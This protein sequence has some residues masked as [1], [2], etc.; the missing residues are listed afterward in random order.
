[1][2]SSVRTGGTVFVLAGGGSLGAV[3]VG[4]LDALVVAGVTPDFVLG[5]SVGAINGVFFASDPSAAGVERL[6]RIWAG[7]SRRDVYPLAPLGWLSP[8]SVREHI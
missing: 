6:G 5:T 1:M 3:Q 2:T 4:M 8:C 7:I